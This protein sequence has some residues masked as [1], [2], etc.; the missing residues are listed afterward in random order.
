MVVYLHILRDPRSGR[1]RAWALRRWQESEEPEPIQSWIAAT[2]AE[3]G[4]CLEA[5]CEQLYAW[6]RAHVVTFGPGSLALLSREM[7][8]TSGFIDD[9]R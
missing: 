2:E 1:P 8:T 5:L 4:A 7:P 6:R 9:I 3:I